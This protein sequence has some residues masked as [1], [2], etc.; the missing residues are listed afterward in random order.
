M[1]G[2]FYFDGYWPLFF[3]NSSNTAEDVFRALGAYHAALGL[4]VGTYQMDPW[5]YGGS[6]GADGPPPPQCH[7]A[8]AWPW[9]GNWSAAPGFFPSG[10]GNLG[11]DLTLYSNIFAQAPLNTM[12]QFPWVNGSCEGLAEAGCAHVTPESSYDFHSYIFDVGVGLG[13]N[14]FE[15][16]SAGGSGRTPVGHSF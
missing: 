1:L 3:S 6:C 15:V 12:T 11:L 8:A 2:A 10:L 14:A 9:A 16:S 7:N 4:T 13:Q 5:W